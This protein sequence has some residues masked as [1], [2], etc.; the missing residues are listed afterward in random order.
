MQMFTMFKSSKG[1]SSLTLDIFRPESMYVAMLGS[2]HSSWSF[3]II[4]I[5]IK[6]K[7]PNFPH[8]TSTCHKTAQPK[9]SYLMIETDELLQN[10]LSGLSD[11]GS[12]HWHP[13]SSPRSSHP[14]QN[15]IALGHGIV[16]P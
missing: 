2:Y 12:R 7:I 6:A 11:G 5:I 8:I 1:I 4:I 9:I 16:Q 15:I 3:V 14:R 10:R 13:L